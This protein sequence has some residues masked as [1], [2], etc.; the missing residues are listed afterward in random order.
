M[1]AYTPNGVFPMIYRLQS[2]SDGYR[3]EGGYGEPSE[4]R[5]KTKIHPEDCQL[6]SDNIASIYTNHFYDQVETHSQS[7]PFIL[8]LLLVS[9]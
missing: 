2:T 5:L 1:L 8:S 4:W 7:Y 9:L 6:T 3:I